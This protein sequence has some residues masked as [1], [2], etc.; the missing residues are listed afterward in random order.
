MTNP[1]QSNSSITTSN[2]TA[3]TTARGTKLPRAVAIPLGLIKALFMAIAYG[4]CSLGNAI[5]HRGKRRSESFTQAD[6]KTDEVAGFNV[7]PKALFGTTVASFRDCLP[8]DTRQDRDRAERQLK[9][10]IR[11]RSDLPATETQL[12]QDF[13]KDI[14]TCVKQFEDHFGYQPEGLYK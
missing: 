11:L 10:L 5:L 1:I 12:A 13:Q 8:S 9:E 3:P 2:V 7:T 6:V 14:D 4:A